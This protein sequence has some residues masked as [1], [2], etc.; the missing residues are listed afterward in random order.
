MIKIKVFLMKCLFVL[1]KEFVGVKLLVLVWFVKV[2]EIF[3]DIGMFVVEDVI[4]YWKVWG[5][6]G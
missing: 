4:I 3:V 1:F 5:E 6:C 2:F